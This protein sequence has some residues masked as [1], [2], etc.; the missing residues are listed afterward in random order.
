MSIETYTLA[1]A[2]LDITVKRK[3]IK[4]LHIG[5]YPPDG[6]VRVSA[7]LQMSKEAIRLALINRLPWIKA[8]RAA[9]QHQPREEKRQYISG[10]THWIEGR[11]HRLNVIEGGKQV[12]IKRGK[13]GW[14]D[15]K[16]PQRASRDT[17]KRAFQ[18]W[19]RRE[20]KKIAAPLI[21][22]RAK[23]MKVALPQ[24]GIKR[25]KTLWGSCNADAR[26]IWLNLELFKKPRPCLDYIIVHELTHLDIRHHNEAFHRRLTQHCPQW[27]TWQTE[28]NQI[29]LAHEEW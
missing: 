8:K 1:L 15:L 21:E 3:P 9:F 6:D 12:R 29:P 14:I 28:L 2:G 24:W 5:A 19:Q 20:L 17:K 25:M 26:R 7:P 16:A 18:N 4:N 27:R 23:Q 10:E 11:P 22:K 13:S